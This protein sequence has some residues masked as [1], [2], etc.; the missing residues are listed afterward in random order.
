MSEILINDKN[1][2]PPGLLGKIYTKLFGASANGY[3]VEI[4]VG[5]CL[6][7]KG[8]GSNTAN[9]ADM[10]WTGLYIEA[11]PNY[12]DEI[13]ERH[14]DNDVKI[15]NAAAGDVDA[16]V[17]L[18]GDTTDTATR[19]AFNKLGWYANV[20]DD[21]DLV[22][23]QR[24]INDI[25]ED[26]NTPA[27]FELM[28]IDVEGVEHKIIG[29][30]EFNKWRP[31]VVMLETRY[32]DSHFISNFPDLVENS[33]QAAQTLL[34]NGYRVVY[35]DHQNSFFLSDLLGGAVLK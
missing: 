34:N 4:G 31:A 14:K 23:K 22:V 3:L 33:K 6:P 11:N 7:S 28:T 20:E 26:A 30:L 10:G 9:L 13:K 5:N 15:I 16:D 1:D 19:D 35:E 25:L 18:K 21:P 29:S 17:N 27:K 32:N 24:P 2:F 8:C 12:I